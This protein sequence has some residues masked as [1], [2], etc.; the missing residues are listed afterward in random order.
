[1][2]LRSFRAEGL[3]FD[4]DR[5]LR[6]HGQVG[7]LDLDPGRRE[8]FPHCGQG[9]GRRGDLEGR[10]FLA[11]VVGA[12]VGRGEHHIVLVRPVRVDE[13]DSSPLEE[14]GHRPART[15]VAVVL[16]E[17]MPDL[18]ARPVPI[19]RQRLN[20]HCDAIRAVALVDHLLVRLAV[21]LRPGAPGD[22]ALD[23]VLRHGVVAR[24][25]DGRRERAV[26]LR[27]RSAVAGGD[28]DRARE[29]REEL[30]PLRVSGALLVLDGRPLAMPGQRSPP[31]QGRGTA[32]GHGC[33]P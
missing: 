1:M 13:D 3:V 32:R 18:G 12:A 19:V 33:R 11:D 10:P 5:R 17:R 16:R 29:L 9:F 7:G 24:L 22:R 21:G 23:V 28:D 14:P 20:E 15:E 30:A 4:L 2:S 8:R 26:P 25:L 6:K 27:V 31:G